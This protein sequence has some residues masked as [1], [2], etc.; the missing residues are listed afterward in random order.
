MID[1]HMHI[2]P[3]VDDGSRFLEESLEMADISASTGVGTI[4]MTPHCN[5]P[6]RYHNYYSTELMN[7]FRHLK[8]AIDQAHIPVQVVPGMEVFTTPDLPELIKAKKVFGLNFSKY[9]LMEFDFGSDPDY[10]TDMLKAVRQTGYIPIVA[11]PERYDAI[12]DD[13]STVE[14]WVNF[15]CLLQSNKSSILGNFGSETAKTVHR[16]LDHQLV[17]FIASDAHRPQV[18]TPHMDQV[19]DYMCWHYSNEVADTLMHNNPLRICKNQPMVKPN[20]IPFETQNYYRMD[21]SFSE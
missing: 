14:A 16:L 1:I 11:H 7:K 20:F 18:R 9:M 17:S 21:L 10:M 3:D 8:A 12:K 19:Y 4:V 13:P 15:G 5:I 2:L 6:Q